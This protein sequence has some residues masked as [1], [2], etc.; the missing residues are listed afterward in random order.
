MFIFLPCCC[1]D[2]SNPLSHQQKSHLISTL[3][4]HGQ[5]CICEFVQFLAIPTVLSLSTQ[6]CRRSSLA[7]AEMQICWDWFFTSTC[8]WI[9]LR[10]LKQANQNQR[11]NHPFWHF[12]CSAVAKSGCF[13]DTPTIFKL[14]C[15]LIMDTGNSS[16]KSWSLHGPTL[17][18]SELTSLTD[19]DFVLFP[20]HYSKQNTL[21][22]GGLESYWLPSRI[23]LRNTKPTS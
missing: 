4:A 17:D 15:T 8:A 20:W 16:M 12:I 1:A 3:K 19:Y 23:Q 9:E 18:L 11:N 22:E 10:K 2:T 13:P 21:K 7:Y 14:A 5:D 6:F